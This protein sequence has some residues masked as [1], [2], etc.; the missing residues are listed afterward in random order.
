MKENIIDQLKVKCAFTTEVSEQ[1]E[2]GDDLEINL[3]GSVVKTEAHDNQ[4]GSVSLVFVFKP[5]TVEVK[6]Q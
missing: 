1:F 5:L 6:K 3:K 4:D 2:L